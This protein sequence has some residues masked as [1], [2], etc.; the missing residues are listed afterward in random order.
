MF[1]FQILIFININ[2]VYVEY[3]FIFITKVT[4]LDFLSLKF[5]MFLL[6]LIYSKEKSKNVFMINMGIHATIIYFTLCL[7]RLV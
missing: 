7:C 4:S 1:L 2:V 5:M 6:I 3:F